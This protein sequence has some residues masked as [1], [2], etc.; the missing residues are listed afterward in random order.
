MSAAA[1]AVVNYPLVA[2][3]VAFALA[4]SSKFFTT[5]F[6]EKRWDARQ[7]I[8]S[9][10]MP[11]SHSATV[12]ALAVAIG[13]QEGYRNATF[14]TSVIIACVVMHDAFGVRL[15]AGKQAEVLNQI[16]Y[17]LPEEHP[18]S[19]TKPLREI[20]G[21]TVPQVVAG[22]ILGILI[23]VVMRLALWSS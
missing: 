9:G 19:E 10:G 1:A 16:V 11:S 6:K 23:A 7:L 17:E 15:H 21:H 22:C 2:A 13:I 8:A 18:L 12:T 3:L 4:Q 14:A 5:W 20:L